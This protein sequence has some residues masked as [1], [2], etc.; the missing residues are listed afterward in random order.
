MNKPIL[1]RVLAVKAHLDAQ[2]LKP[3]SIELGKVC[4]AALVADCRALD[5][6]QAVDQLLGM[7]VEIVPDFV[8]RD[9]KGQTYTV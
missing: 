5:G 7:K 8:V 1:E 4:L 2:D 3:V 9:E 6:D